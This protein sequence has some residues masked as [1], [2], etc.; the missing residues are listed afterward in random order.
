MH[1]F[2]SLMCKNSQGLPDAIFFGTRNI[3]GMEKLSQFYC[4]AEITAQIKPQHANLTT[5]SS[6]KQIL[7]IT[8]MI[9]RVKAALT[10]QSPC[11]LQEREFCK[12]FKIP[13]KTLVNFVMTAEDHYVKDNPYHNHL[14]AADVTQSTHILLNSPNLDVSFLIILWQCLSTPLLQSSS[15]SV[16][17]HT[18]RDSLGNFCFLH[19]RY[20]SPWVD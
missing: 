5:K 8:Y 2:C 7:I 3:L 14:H 4:A 16:C 13:Q 15:F 20:R 17:L 18:F 1:A 11:L 9:D 12:I 19:S 6:L 10:V